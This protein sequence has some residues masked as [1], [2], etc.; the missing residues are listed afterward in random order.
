M[1]PSV[2]VTP[3]PG[4]EP[5]VPWGR[6][7]YTFVTSAAGHM[8]RTLQKPRKNRP[9]KRQVNHR[10]FLHNMIQRKF[11]DIEAANRRLASALYIQEAESSTPE[12]SRDHPDGCKGQSDNQEV[13]SRTKRINDMS[14]SCPIDEVLHTHQDEDAM[15]IPRSLTP[16]FSPLSFDPMQLFAEGSADSNNLADVTES[17]WAD[18]MD[19]FSEDEETQRHRD[20]FPESGERN[21]GCGRYGDDGPIINRFRTETD[22]L[23]AL[24]TCQHKMMSS[25][26]VAQSF[27][28]PP[29]D[30]S[31]RQIVTPPLEDHLMFTDIL[32]DVESPSCTS[33][34]TLWYQDVFA[35]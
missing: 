21:R 30:A 8:M 3:E 11:A 14:L 32:M 23:P 1:Q 12:Q 18:I 2:S 35:Q 34:N 31:L 24:S 4:L 13:Q 27:W 28:A 7:L 33:F 6:D 20:G 25:G 9:S 26:G 15:P 17:D 29:H 19:L 22:P 16:P 5:G 10:R